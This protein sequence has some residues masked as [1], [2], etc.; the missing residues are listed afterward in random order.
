M[1]IKE[2]KYNIDCDASIPEKATIVVIALHGFAGWTGRRAWFVHGPGWRYSITAIFPDFSADI[3]KYKTDDL[4]IKT[5]EEVNN[6][7]SKLNPD[8]YLESIDY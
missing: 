8:F 2:K 6:I 3:F 1:I 4:E 7:L 5:L